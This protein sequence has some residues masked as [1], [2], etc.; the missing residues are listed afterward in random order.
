M[1]EPSKEEIAKQVAQS[2]TWVAAHGADGNWLRD[3][4]LIA[5]ADENE[6]LLT[7]LREEGESNVELRA[8]LDGVRDENERLRAERAECLEAFEALQRMA[9]T[10]M[11]SW[12]TGDAID[13]SRVDELCEDMIAKLRGQQP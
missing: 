6:R 9:K 12:D 13:A 11:L 8:K 1:S 2:R 4:S 3:R 10:P 5:L 7:D